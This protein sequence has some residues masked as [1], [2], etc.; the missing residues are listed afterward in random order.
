MQKIGKQE[1]IDAGSDSE[2]TD[3][4]ADLALANAETRLLEPPADSSQLQN[5]DGIE[6]LV[7]MPTWREVLLDLVKTENFDPWN[8][9]IGTI[10]AAYIERVKKMRSVDLHVPSNII[11]AA[12]ILLRMKSELLQLKEEEQVVENA[13]FMEGTPA[14]PIEV[15]MLQLRVRVPPKR[16]I[17][18]ADVINALE[19]VIVLEKKREERARDL[20]AAMELTIPTYNIEKEM[21]ATLEKAKKLADSEGWLTFSQLISD[22]AERTAKGVVLTLLPVLHLVQEGEFHVAQEKIFGEIFIRVIDKTSSKA[23]DE[24]IGS[25]GEKEEMAVAVSGVKHGRSRKAD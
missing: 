19:E 13:V 17:T 15:S 3:A 18:L 21:Q 14:E 7:G 8:I 20:P 23:E 16:S 24:D 25:G 22:K 12:A 9:D 10:T 11:L 5:I 6:K 1:D 2:L 4:V